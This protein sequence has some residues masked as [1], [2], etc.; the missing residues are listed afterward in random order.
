MRIF[1]I[2]G[3]I[4]KT[5]LSI[6]AVVFMKPDGLG[7]AA[8]IFAAVYAVIT[9]YIFSFSSGIVTC[10]SDDGLTGL[11]I[12]LLINL[13]IPA[14][15]LVIPLF[16]LEAILPG[17]IGSI[18]YGIGVVIAGVWCLISDVMHT[19]DPDLSIDD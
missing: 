1:K 11:V 19:I 8:V 14:L 16:I 3:T 17:E 15:V 7:S 5:A 10:V 18:I 6:A 4:A 13:C 9:W 12:G 2:L